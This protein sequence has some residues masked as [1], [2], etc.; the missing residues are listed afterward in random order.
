MSDETKPEPEQINEQA[1]DPVS[2]NTSKF[3]TCDN[4]DKVEK[5]SEHKISPDSKRLKLD[6]TPPKVDNLVSQSVADEKDKPEDK[7]SPEKKAI[8]EEQKKEEAPK[9]CSDLP[10]DPTK[11][12]KASE[13]KVTRVVHQF[14]PTEKAVV[15]SDDA[16]K[17]E[18]ASKQKEVES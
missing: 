17:P 18:E 7:A 10:K 9:D 16:K 15:A 2:P 4:G 13:S 12:T 14:E 1:Q 11:D 5:T 6:D 8:E 3:N